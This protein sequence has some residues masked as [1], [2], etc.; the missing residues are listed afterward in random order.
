MTNISTQPDKQLKMSEFSKHF[1]PL[2]NMY[3]TALI[4]MILVAALIATGLVTSLK[5]SSDWTLV[6]AATLFLV[7]MLLSNYY[8]RWHKKRMLLR[9]LP[10]AN[11]RCCRCH[12]GQMFIDT[13]SVSFVETLNDTNHYQVSLR[14]GQHISGQYHHEGNR[15]VH[16]TQTELEELG[17]ILTQE[18]AQ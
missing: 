4:A 12:Q 3:I 7:A 8:S 2:N 10:A 18:I 17:I 5:S 13:H 14:C 6:L 9:Y 16:L 1:D 11:K 15:V